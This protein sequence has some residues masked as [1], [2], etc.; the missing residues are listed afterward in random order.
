MHHAQHKKPTLGSLFAGI[1]GFDVGF[2]RAGW[3]TSW[4]VELDPLCRTVLTSRFQHA[5][6]FADV[7]ESGAHNLKWVDCIT[8]GFPCQDISTSGGRAGKSPE[9]LAGERSGL[10]FQVARILR[11]LQPTWVVLENVAHLLAVND[12]R[13]LETI[14]GTL[15]DCGYV[16]FWRVLDAQ[17]FGSSAR[18]RRVFLVAGL[19]R[20]PPMEFLAD[21]RAVDTIPSAIGAFGQPRQADGWPGNTIQAANTPSRITIGGELLIAEE[22]GWH[23]MAERARATRDYGI[24]LG[25]DETSLAEAR[26]AGNAVSPYVAEWIARIL[27]KESGLAAA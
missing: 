17:H 27:G 20:Y 5:E 4:Q 26:A 7:R 1:G 11:E 14:L 12:S 9:G 16:G 24:C 22:D 23:Q 21:A 13:D 6:Q 10:F 8:A 25:L 3:E 15:A 2:E 19:G 18:R